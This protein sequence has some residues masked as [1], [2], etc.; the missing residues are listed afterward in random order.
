MYRVDDLGIEVGP[1]V[2]PSSTTGDLVEDGGLAQRTE[3][4]VLISRTRRPRCVQRM[5]YGAVMRN[6]T[7]RNVP[8]SLARSLDEEKRLR[9]RSLNQTVLELL[10]QAV[11]IAG[12]GRRSNGL[13]ALGGRWS[14]DEVAELEE[15]LRSTE[16][17]DPEL[18]R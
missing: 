17:L 11:G 12:G 1:F 16:E 13:A 15:A 10:G 7:I 5:R 6:I 18:W 2:S 4:L 8:E 3:D 9:G 14:R